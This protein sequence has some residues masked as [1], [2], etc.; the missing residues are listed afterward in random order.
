[1]QGSPYRRTPEIAVAA[2]PEPMLAAEW[3]FAS[4]F[5]LTSVACAAGII[6]GGKLG[7][8]GTLALIVVIGFP[9]VYFKLRRGAPT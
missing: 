1:M 9:V 3:F 7:A 6:A 2:T 8:E 5:W 4:A